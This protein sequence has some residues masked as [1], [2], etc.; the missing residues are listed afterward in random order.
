M[1]SVF[2]VDLVSVV[3][4]HLKKNL[5]S[6]QSGS[7]SE[8]SVFTKKAMCFSCY[9]A[10]CVFTASRSVYVFTLEVSWQRFLAF[11]WLMTERE[12]VTQTD[13]EREKERERDL[14]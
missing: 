9:G 6:G 13:G 11:L 5:T 2:L 10:I 8:W 7:C 1:I 12:A 3:V 4:V 14:N